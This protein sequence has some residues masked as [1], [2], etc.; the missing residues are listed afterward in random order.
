MK[1]D[2]EPASW[3]EQQK[4]FYRA[5]PHAHLQFNPESVYAK[6]IVN[7]VLARTGLRSAKNILEVGC[8]SGRFTLHLVRK[9]LHLTAL[10]FSEEQ[11][12]NLTQAAQQLVL[13]PDQ[14]LLRSGDISEAEKLFKR[15]QFDSIIGFFFLHH[16]ENIPAALKSLGRILRKGGEVIFVEPNRLNILFLAQIFLCKDM[17]WKAEKGTFR[18]GV[19]RYRH[20]LEDSGYTATEITKF[21]FFPPQLLDK[22]PLMLQIEK[23]IEKVPLTKIFLPFL[24]IRGK[25]SL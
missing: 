2:S 23:W 3:A 9:G 4:E 11:L 22:F 15:Q 10:D 13:E 18:C 21:G 20:C 25:K 16:L 14:L 24:L 7:E 12:N 19:L 6:N 8:G 1:L 5:L 17:T